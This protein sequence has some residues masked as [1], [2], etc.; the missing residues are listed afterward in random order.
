MGEGRRWSECLLPAVDGAS[1]RGKGATCRKNDQDP[2]DENSNADHSDYFE[3]EG[4]EGRGGG[5]DSGRIFFSMSS[6]HSNLSFK[7]LPSYMKAKSGVEMDPDRVSPLHVW[8]VL[9]YLHV[10]LS[11]T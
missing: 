2:S 4:E 10:P 6:L 9:S 3:E 5:G 7:S 8:A 11:L 1:S